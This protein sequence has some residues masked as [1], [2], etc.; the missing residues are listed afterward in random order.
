[1]W[2]RFGTVAGTAAT[3]LALYPVY[4]S[5]DD[6]KLIS[7]SSSAS[8]SPSTADVILLG[9]TV[10]SEVSAAVLRRDGVRHAFIKVPDRKN[11]AS[12]DDRADVAILSKRALFDLSF[13][14]HD[15]SHNVTAKGVI[16]DHLNV[17]FPN[18]SVR[19]V[20]L[21]SSDAHLFPVMISI[22][23]WELLSAISS[24]WASKSV[25]TT[26]NASR[27]VEVV[28]HSNAVSVV[29]EDEAGGTF[30]IQGSYLIDSRRNEGAVQ[31][32]REVWIGSPPPKSVESAAVASQLN[33]ERKG[34]WSWL[35]GR[36]T[37]TRSAAVAAPI[38][39]HP[40]AHGNMDFVWD[41][42]M[43]TVKNGGLH[44]VYMTSSTD[45]SDAL[46]K[47][48]Q[49]FPDVSNWSRSMVASGSVDVTP[50]S[51][52]VPIGRARSNI[53]NIIDSTQADAS[54]R[55]ALNA[56]TKLSCVSRGLLDPSLA[57]RSLH[58]ELTSGVKQN[59]RIGNFLRHVCLSRYVPLTY[60]SQALS[61]AAEW[62][63]LHPRVS[64]FFSLAGCD[65][66]RPSQSPMNAV[67]MDGDFGRILQRPVYERV[68]NATS[69]GCRMPVETTFQIGLLRLCDLFNDESAKPVLLLL[70]GSDESR[71]VDRAEGVLEHLY[72]I[73]SAVAARFSEN[74]SSFVVLPYTLPMSCVNLRRDQRAIF[75][76][77][78]DLHDA[79]HAKRFPSAALLYPDGY[80]SFIAT[81]CTEEN[82]LA[83]LKS[84]FP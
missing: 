28:E 84:V 77:E 3:A 27:V 61:F 11:D 70:A 69:V 79:F 45:S 38:L 9:D 43:F 72:H 54:I 76:S 2:K 16:I 31:R 1:M 64:E 47:L 22:P 8:A 15:V 30:T 36:R 82:V 65:S 24:L 18:T 35:F 55:E 41:E 6:V 73:R 44:R 81:P 46:A 83:Y 48:S 68:W 52:V 7:V 37:S 66:K 29:C 25:G 19:T 80:V 49:R 20:S 62:K 33:S 53:D 21:D 74:V 34:W 78:A 57:L 56:A 10:A 14:D 50:S 42:D 40:M 58:L 71:S 39:G 60:L 51:R 12:M 17:V 23:V 75:D 13:L 32:Q 63:N 26:V 4:K 59:G 67:F 5:Y